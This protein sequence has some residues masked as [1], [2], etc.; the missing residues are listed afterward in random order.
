MLFHVCEDGVHDIPSCEMQL[1]LCLIIAGIAVRFYAA[2]YADYADFRTTW[3][4]D[5]GKIHFYDIITE[6]VY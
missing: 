4:S 6:P 5:P 2:D 3:D 1:L